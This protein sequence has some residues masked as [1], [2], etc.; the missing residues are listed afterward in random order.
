MQDVD[1][2]NQKIL[3]SLT[4]RTDK[5]DRLIEFV[6]KDE[7]YIGNYLISEKDSN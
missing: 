6:F 2:S 1:G 3:I 7:A 4:K 5:R